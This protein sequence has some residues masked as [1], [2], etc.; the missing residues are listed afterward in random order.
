MVWVEKMGPADGTD[1]LDE[2]T[3]VKERKRYDHFPDPPYF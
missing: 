1:V 2:Y 3:Q